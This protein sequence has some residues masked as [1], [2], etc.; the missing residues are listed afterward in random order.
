GRQIVTSS[1]DKKARLWDANSGQ[2]LVVMEDLLA[3][4]IVDW[5]A[6]LKSICFVTGGHDSIYLWKVME[7]ED[8]YQVRLHRRLM[9]DRLSV[10][11]TSIQDAQ[12]LSDINMQLLRQREAVGD[13]I[14]Q[15]SLGEASWKP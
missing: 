5:N 1:E 7:E 14:L 15:S 10:L 13:P 3:V 11:N 4:R 2:S 6:T 9:Q 8:Y 12:G